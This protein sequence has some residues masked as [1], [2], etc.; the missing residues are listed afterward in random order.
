MVGCAALSTLG[1]VPLRFSEPPGSEPELRILGPAPDRPLGGASLRLY[2]RIENPN[3]VGL[4]LRQ[5]A[6]D[7][8]I[9]DAEAIGVDFPLGLPL[10]AGQDT[11]IPLDVSLRFDRLP[12]LAALARTA[13]TG[14]PLGYRLEG[15]FSVDAGNLGRPRFGPLTLL[16]GSIRVR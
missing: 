2:A 16:N 15:S 10:S 8:Y 5:V 6:G 1:I 4:T 14:S 7:L 3:Q 11:I 13:L 12:R 9:E